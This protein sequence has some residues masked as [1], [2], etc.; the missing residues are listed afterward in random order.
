[1]NVH[2]I[3]AVYIVNAVQSTDIY[4]IT[5]VKYAVTNQ[6]NIKTMLYAYIIYTCTTKE[7]A[8][9]SICQQLTYTFSTEIIEIILIEIQSFV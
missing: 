7:L 9:I 6:L 1:M 4:C 3:N 2:T 5:E 8:S